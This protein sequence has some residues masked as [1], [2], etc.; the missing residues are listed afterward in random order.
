MK[1][2]STGRLGRLFFSAV[3]LEGRCPGSV[4]I[5][6][7]NTTDP[8][9]LR[10]ARHSSMTLCDEQ[11]GG[12][13]LIEL[14]VVVL[15]IGILS[16]IALPQYRVAVAKSRFVQLQTLGTAI[17]Q[18]EERYLMSNAEY[19]QDFRNLD[20][21]FPGELSDEGRTVRYKGFAC[22]LFFGPGQGATEGS[23]IDYKEIACRYANASTSSGQ[24]VPYFLYGF[25]SQKPYCRAYDIS[26]VQA[27]VCQS[28][29]GGKNYCQTS[30]G[31]CDYFL[32]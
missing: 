31:Y 4:V 15:I 30:L 12:F 2:L 27:Q 32:N 8:G 5:N 13:T 19:T 10:A 29:G 14:L 7:R 20:L 17:Q 23:V 22:T 1:N 26:P 9:T 21:S 28:Y 16:A 3:T 6:K 18:A 11:R 24:N 25:R